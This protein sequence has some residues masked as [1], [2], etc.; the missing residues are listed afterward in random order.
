LSQLLGIVPAAD[1]ALE[2]VEVTGSIGW[3]PDTGMA[4]DPGTR[5]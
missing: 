5:R 2:D 3:A 1:R 4:G